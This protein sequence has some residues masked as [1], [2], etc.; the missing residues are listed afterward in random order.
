MIR[1]L[2]IQILFITLFTGGIYAQ[3]K[4]PAVQEKAPIIGLS[5]TY[6]TGQ[7]SVPNTY[8]IAVRKAGGIPVV[9]P[10]TDDP[11]II[12]RM[13]EAIDGLILTGGEDLDPLRW[14]G[15][16]P[17]PAM[18]AIVP[19]R[20]FF[21]IHLARTAVEQGIP[22]LGICRG[23]Q[24]L[25]VAFGGTLYQDIPSQVRSDT[26]VKHNQRAPREYG[27]HTITVTEGTVLHNLLKDV[28]EKDNT[29]RVNSYH[30]QA[31]KDLAPGFIISAYAKDGVPEAIEM[32]GNPHVLGVQFHPEGPVSQGDHALLPLFRHVVEAAR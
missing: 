16:E 20:D 22:V 3:S 10:V 1:T 5:A 27:S 2:F 29:F 31:V 17:L 4:E 28:L 7:N 12:L 9:L 8:I 18:G 11:E 6:E 14:Y 24:T 32:M 19:I 13:V 25:N 26:P 21:D 23:E 30:H 15:E